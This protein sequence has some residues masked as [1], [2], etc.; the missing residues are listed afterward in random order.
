MGLT[1]DDKVLE[2]AALFVRSG[3]TRFTGGMGAWDMAGH[4]LV[5]TPQMTVHQIE[6][7]TDELQV[8]DVR[9]PSEWKS[10]HVPCATHLFVPEIR[11]GTG[12]LDQSKPVVTYCASGYRASIGA[13]L[14]QRAGFKDVRTLPGSWAAWRAAGLP[15]SKDEEVQ[16]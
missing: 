2:V 4:R 15:V 14:Q 8:V 6:T 10:G 11:E 12:A 9:E 7:C 5:E 13:R 1:G 16:S 3:Y